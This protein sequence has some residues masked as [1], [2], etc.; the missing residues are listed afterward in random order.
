MAPVGS[1][2]GTV[3]RRTRVLALTAYVP[4]GIH[5]TIEVKLKMF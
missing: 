1:R 3:T 4:R 5:G 2:D